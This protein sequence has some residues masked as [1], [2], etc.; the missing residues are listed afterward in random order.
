M[1]VQPGANEFCR[2]LARTTRSGA[3]CKE[4]DP[5]TPRKAGRILVTRTRAGILAASRTPRI[6]VQAIALRRDRPWDKMTHE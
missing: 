5:K 6:S 2:A 4:I 3:E 1:Q